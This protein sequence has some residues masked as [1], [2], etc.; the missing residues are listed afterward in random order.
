MSQPSFQHYIIDSMTLFES[1]QTYESKVDSDLMVYDVE[2]NSKS[3]K[4]ALLY[5]FGLAF[6][7]QKAFYIPWRRQDGSKVWTPEEELMII[8][9]LHDTAKTKK[10]IGH[11][12]IY[13]V[14]V[15]ENNLGF[16]MDKY[17]HSDTILMKHMVDEEIPF[18]LKE[19]AVIILGDWAD[20]AQD[21]LKDEV[22][23]NGG[24]WNA[25]DKDMFLA[26]TL[27]LGEY[28]CWDVI[29]TIMLY[30]HFDEKMQKEGLYKLFDEEVMPL[31]KTVT[32][33]MKRKGFNIDIEYYKKLKTDIE[34]EIE[35]LEAG[36]MKDISG[37]IKD[38]EIKL[39]E[40]AYP[41]KSTGNFPK[42]YADYYRIVLPITKDGKVTLASKAV[43]AQLEVAQA[44]GASLS[45]INFYNGIIN[46]TLESSSAIIATAPSVQ[47]AMFFKDNPTSK[48]VFNLHSN[49]DLIE[50]VFG[51]WGFSPEDY[52]PGGKPKINDE[53]LDT[54]K[55]N[56]VID[57]LKDYKKLNKLL[58]TYVEG[59]LDRQIDG[60]IYTSMLQ[61]GTTSGRY[62]SRDPNLQN[63]PR[64][65]DDDSGLST[66]VL[67][68]VNA[69]R[70]GFVAPP[71]Y[72]IVNA[73]Y[74]SLEPVCFAHV[75][76]DEKLRD[77]F[78][79]GED[80]YSRVGIETF[81]L[82]GVSAKKSDPNYL[83][84]IHPEI[85]QTAKII[86]LAIPYGAEAAR[87]SQELGISFKEANDIVE[88]YLNGFPDL[89]RYMMRQ[90]HTAKTKGFVTTQFG[91][92]RHLPEAKSIYVLYGDG[93]LD[94]KYSKKIGK[95][96]IR[97]KFKN[98]LNN[99]KN[100]PIQ[101][102]AAHIVNRAMIAIAKEFQIQNIDG[103]IALQVHDE[104]TC[105]VR[106]DQ[107]QRA[108]DIVKFCM[109]QTTTI[110]VPLVAEP[111]IAD[112]WA[113]AK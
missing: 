18:G 68:Y 103:W 29:L 92:V 49:D 5:G 100:F 44:A 46:K 37:D 36:I 73:D 39:L 23:A 77:V 6:T 70:R 105:V 60:I 56:P 26:S 111:L 102:L 19:N 90:N 7:D 16:R 72:K 109:E 78:R 63:Q 47:K 101:G 71:G 91:R 79:N 106:E 11:N 31:Y 88:K 98:N 61:F 24:R 14:L 12:I 3:E 35:T 81:N 40:E 113:D 30:K 65:K 62:S 54:L 86:A 51:K 108:S 2:T 33:D 95:E 1:L 59:I 48:Y 42:M 55:G 4:T 64:I 9:W 17:I 107:A 57:K 45:T 97:R 66:L 21:K 94:W 34:V 67:T 38:Y 96:D 28:C 25:G 75:S 104:I 8:K 112:N 74:A 85:R 15:T 10:L 20:K 27:T 99:S 22:I 83:K 53:Y 32:I 80:L 84:N 87:I 13:D 110:S 43:K 89:R 76:G 41:I 52:T 69:I 93:I 82:K 58:S 50:L